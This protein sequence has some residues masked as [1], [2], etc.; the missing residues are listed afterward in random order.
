MEK[1]FISLIC[2]LKYTNII[3]RKIKIY[4]YVMNTNMTF[5]LFPG[6]IPLRRGKTSSFSSHYERLGWELEGRI[7]WCPCLQQPQE[8]CEAGQ[9]TPSPGAP[10]RRVIVGTKC[11][12]ETSNSSHLA[13][14]ERCKL[15][16]PS[17][18]TRKLTP[19]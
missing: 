7:Q 3:I 11:G 19:K 9:A 17:E 1:Y 15:V 10:F 2:K 12:G 5:T 8:S 16:Q 13:H 4:F 6:N 18:K 14:L